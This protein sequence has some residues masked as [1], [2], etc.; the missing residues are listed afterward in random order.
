M[1]YFQTV[2]AVA[3]VGGQFNYSYY[4][5]WENSSEPLDAGEIENRE[6]DS[7]DFEDTYL[8]RKRK[9][10]NKVASAFI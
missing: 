7:S 1:N 2:A 4:D 10:N 3:A 5:E 6:S 9:R 8:K